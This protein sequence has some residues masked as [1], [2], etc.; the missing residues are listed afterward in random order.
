M[1]GAEGLRDCIT[2]HGPTRARVACLVSALFSIL[3]RGHGASFFSEMAPQK[4]QTD[5]TE[6]DGLEY[7]A[8]R[9]ASSGIVSKDLV[10]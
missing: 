1:P 7:S 9:S 10:M 4:G 3:Q 8:E 2:Y 6:D 5:I